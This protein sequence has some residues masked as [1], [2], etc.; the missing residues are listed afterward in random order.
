MGPTGIS[1]SSSITTSSTLYGFPN[2][3]TAGPT[4]TGGSGTE[5]AD[6]VATTSSSSSAVSSTTS[7]DEYSYP[8]YYTFTSPPAS[9]SSGSSTT[10]PNSTVTV[11]PVSPGTTGP[12]GTSVS[13]FDPMSTGPSG[14]APTSYPPFTNSSSTSGSISTG[15][16]GTTGGPLSTGVSTTTYTS[17]SSINSSTSAIDP[18]GTSETDTSTSVSDYPIPTYPVDWGY[19]YESYSSVEETTVVLTSTISATGTSTSTLSSPSDSS[20]VT[21]SGNSTAT[22]TITDPILAHAESKSSRRFYRLQRYPKLPTKQPYRMRAAASKAKAV[23]LPAAVSLDPPPAPPLSTSPTALLEPLL[24]IVVVPLPVVSSPAVS[25]A[26]DEASAAD[27]DVLLIMA[28]PEEVGVGEVIIVM[29]ESPSI[30]VEEAIMLEPP[31]IEEGPI[32]LAPVSMAE[33]DSDAELAIMVAPVRTLVSM[34]ATPFGPAA[35]EPLPPEPISC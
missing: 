7:S 29:L 4:G 9:S 12:T 25:E 32:M 1:N 2:S 18:I 34:L 13:S 16:S 8:F 24:P 11:D 20:S 28:E 31:I 10:S 17:Y 19:P 14:T 3:T 5:T 35:T 15:P 26:V 21:W 30:M 27:S 22:T 23:T 6:P 33:A